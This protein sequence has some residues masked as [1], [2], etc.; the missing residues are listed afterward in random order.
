MRITEIIG[1][2]VVFAM[3]A[4]GLNAQPAAPPA[5][6]NTL[7]SFLGIPQGVN[8]I[9]DATKNKNG[10]R[11]ERER[12]PPL[13]RIADPANLESQNPAIKAAAKV[14]TEE[15]LAPQKVKAIKYL[16]TIGCGCYPGVREA[17]LAALDDCTEEVRYQAA[18]AFCQ[19]AG[20]HCDK[21]GT[22][23]CNAAV[24]SKLAE[25]AHG[26]D[27]KGCFKESSARVRAAAENALN[28]CRRM[29][30]PS[31]TPAAPETPK[32]ELPIQSAP[33]A[34]E[35]PSSLETP[36]P[37]PNSGTE[38]RPDRGR[39]NDRAAT[40][41][42][43]NMRAKVDLVSSMGFVEVGDEDAGREKPADAVAMAP[44][45]LKCRP[46]RCP[47]GRGTIICPEERPTPAEPGKA[48]PG[49]AAPGAPGEPAVPPPSALAGNYG[50]ASGP[51]S[52][53]PNMIG[54]FCSSGGNVVLRTFVIPP[55]GDSTILV[56][57]T[58]SSGN[59]AI[60]GGDRAFKIA[61]N[62]NPIPTDRVFFNYNHYQN[63]VV[64]ARGNV[65]N[66]DRYTFGVEKTFLNEQC[67]VEVRIPFAGGLNSTQSLEPD[68]ALMGTEFG[69]IP[70]VFKGI[71][72]KWDNAVLAAAVVVSLPTAR[73]A[74][75][76]DQFGTEQIS[77]RNDA[78]HVGPVVGLLW[79]P[80][81]R[82]FVEGFAQA[83]FDTRGNDVFVNTGNALA[84]AGTVQD[85]S[86]L[87]LDLAVG[88]WIYKN[89]C[90]RWITGVVPTVELH[91]TTTMQDADV[92]NGPIQPRAGVSAFT[93][94]CLDNRRDVVDLTAGVHFMMGPCTT[95][96]VAAVAPLRTGDDRE[97]DAEV[98]AQLN[99]RF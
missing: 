95:L 37:A 52:A 88:R 36:V 73:D 83:D 22:S 15:D 45:P 78:I 28:A 85:Q 17:L 97:F 59:V 31:P 32:K 38:F 94:G 35:P 58:Q 80:G 93:V 81:D 5:A 56:P 34:P 63:P 10:N 98:L 3:L 24:M 55:G 87:Y 71:L 86:L 27:E 2:I 16:A 66:L 49:E 14:K 19:A 23:C 46:R 61:E 41:I 29:I 53:A 57:V 84:Q 18:I 79:T 69:N 44:C 42:R 12:K 26:Q 48:A 75:L 9:K 99:R 51:M 7:W 1:G 33:V 90:A 92:V 6:P 91:Y 8:K 25:K 13:K 65:R 70:L 68:A 39:Q 30:P 43:G 67:S 74:R 62:S 21:C 54:D 60:A 47:E 4:T 64:D 77:V 96:T 72:R 82:W 20:D 11:P 89:P 40:E 50:A 76:F